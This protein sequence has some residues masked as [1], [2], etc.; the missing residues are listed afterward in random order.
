MDLNFILNYSGDYTVDI[1][2]GSDHLV[3]KIRVNKKVIGTYNHERIP[4]DN[5]IIIIIG[6]YPVSR[7]SLVTSNPIRRNYRWALDFKYD[8]FEGHSCWDGIDSISIINS[9]D[10][11]DKLFD[12]L[13]EFKKMQV[14]L[15]KVYRQSAIFESPTNNHYVN[16]LFGCF[17]SHIC[18]LQRLSK[19]EHNNMVIFEDDFTFTDPIEENMNNISKFF[20]RGYTYDVLLLATS[21]EGNIIQRDDLIG[22]SYQP[23]TTTSGYILSKR[24]LG[25][26]L[27]I[28]EKAN[29][30]LCITGDFNKY[31]CDRYWSLI[32]VDNGMF[33]FNKKI[34]YQRPSISQTSKSLSYNLD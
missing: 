19:L 22:N 4:E 33:T 30:M 32:Q 31:A 23:C 9:D 7:D 6:D 11:P 29:E 20:N 13:K 18:N 28:W 5:E 2:N 24:G 34:G 14:P 1:I 10:R 26:I 12:I 15:N 16:G 27:P 21:A 3:N 25:V 8:Y 17:K